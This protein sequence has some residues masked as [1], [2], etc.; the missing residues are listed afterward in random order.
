MM[1]DRTPALAFVTAISCITCG[2]CSGSRT[3]AILENAL[4]CLAWNDVTGL[5]V[6]PVERAAHERLVRMHHDLAGCL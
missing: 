4:T 5:V 3:S 1:T 2:V 6:P